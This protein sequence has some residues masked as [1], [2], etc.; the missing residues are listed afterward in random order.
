MN[1]TCNK[2]G[3]SVPAEQKFCTSCGGNEFTEAAAVQPTVA[4]VQPTV[5]PVQ[6]AVAPVT[7]V[8]PVAGAQPPKKGMPTWL[9]VILII[10]LVLGLLGACTVGCVVV[11]IGSFVNEVN[12]AI[13][14][15]ES[16]YDYD[17]DYDYDDED[18]STDTGVYG[19]EDTFTFDDLEI[20][21][22]SDYTFTTI[23]N[24]YSDYYG[25]DIVRVPVTVTN[26]STET[27]GLNMFYY[28]IYGTTGTKV[29]NVSTWFSDDS[30][31]Y[32][33]DLR[34]GASYTK[35]IYFVYD[36]DGTYVF[37]FDNYSE[38]VEVE[39]EISK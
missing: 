7:P 16:D 27:H 33:G 9:K 34:S 36:A 26:K 8:A 3:A 6:P 37:E 12:E 11:G 17:Y 22:G 25:K 39:L 4:P 5:A 10:L 18:T 31:D 1:K 20:T 24:Q 21:F 32:A 28:T 30:L 14:D 29:N 38:E 15:S 19:F 13:E 23:S 2:C 35:Y